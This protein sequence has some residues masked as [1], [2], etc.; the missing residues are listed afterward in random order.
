MSS[1]TLSPSFSRSSLACF[2]NLPLKGDG[3]GP[4]ACPRS[5]AI[6]WPHVIPTNRM[7][8]RTGTRP[9]H[10]HRP[11]PCP[12]RCGRAF[13]R[14]PD[15]GCK[16]SQNEATPH[17]GSK[18]SSLSV[19]VRNSGQSGLI[20]GPFWVSQQMWYDRGENRR[21][22]M[23]SPRLAHHPTLDRRRPAWRGHPLV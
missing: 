9:P 5:G 23:E 13:N 21:G 11:T 14:I 6:R 19:A 12:Y 4:G 15:F 10:P 1:Y 18:A 8:T 7:T 20:P 16:C 2:K 22:W 17:Y 3:R